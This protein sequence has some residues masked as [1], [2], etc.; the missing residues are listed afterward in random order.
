WVNSN[1]TA[2]GYDIVQDSVRTDGLAAY[3]NIYAFGSMLATYF[4]ST[5][6]IYVSYA[7]NLTAKFSMTGS[8][9]SFYGGLVAYRNASGGIMVAD[10]LGSTSPSNIIST[11]IGMSGTNTALYDKTIV[12]E[13]NN[14][15]YYTTRKVTIPASF[16]IENP[17]D[18]NYYTIET[19]YSTS[20]EY[21]WRVVGCDNAFS[22]NDSSCTTSTSRTFSVDNE[23]PTIS[24]IS[25]T[26]DSV[27]GGM[28]RVWAKVDDTPGDYQ[29]VA[30]ANYT[31]KY[32]DNSTIKFQGDMAQGGNVWNSGYLDFSDETLEDFTLLI[33]AKD[34]MGHWAHDHV[35]F[36]VNN[37]TPWFLFGTGSDEITVDGLKTFANIIQ[38]DFI[39]YNVLTSNLRIV[40]PSPS[41]TN[42]FAQS[43]INLTITNHNYSDDISTATWPDGEYTVY[44]NATTLGDLDRTDS[45][46]FWVDKNAPQWSDASPT[47][48]F[49][50][51]DLI[52]YINWTDIT[53]QGVNFTYNNTNISISTMLSENGTLSNGLYRSSALD[54]SSFRGST[55]YWKSEAI[56]RRNQTNSTG[57][58]TVTVKN[59][60]PTEPA[61]TNSTTGGS[62]PAIASTVGGVVSI[63][64]NASTDGDDDTL[65]YSLMY[66]NDLSTWKT[67]ATGLTTN[68]YSWDT[69]LNIT[70]VEDVFLLVNVTD[71]VE[72]NLSARY[73]NFTV[74]NEA[75]AITITDPVNIVVGTS[76]PAN[77]TTS[78][79]ATCTFGINGSASLSQSSTS[80]TSHI[81][82]ISS[83]AYNN[84][85]NLSVSCEDSVGNTN[86]TSKLF[87]ARET[88]LA[89]SNAWANKTV[90]IVNESVNITFQIP[91][92][93]DLVAFNWT[94][95]NGTTTWE[96]GMSHV[97]PDITS[98]NDLTYLNGLASIS[99]LAPGEYN[100]TITNL[101]SSLDADVADPD[102]EVGTIFE[103][104][105][106]FSQTINV[107]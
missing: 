52:L 11:Y 93:S 73:G 5:S 102:I 43:R 17:I 63:T 107:E 21:D 42:R 87:Q 46:T 24:S 95:T 38:S 36:T 92:R 19:N 2:Y 61:I 12:F 65:Y 103:V 79:S 62:T 89:F 80:G 77:I 34:H 101:T 27:V 32:K 88:G 72:G 25:P 104:F 39:A 96:R 6:N 64:W 105:T 56:D 49:A 94:I 3:S 48:I 33:S 98:T 99:T 45:R 29:D 28:F 37:A 41:T 90:L 10:I 69:T 1:A 74:D 66:S 75:P 50:S 31:V 16:I 91:T 35:N 78:E 84:T 54:V 23:A 57:W 83:L 82:T 53:L 85:Y 67:I 15:L 58:Q 14:N 4:D 51:E 106:Q 71:G 9:L 26:Q 86:E 60:A 20:T 97:S 55:F 68:S 13:N 22:N 70:A 18:S 100:L 7:E 81:I 47:E 59:N 40:G 8:N 44:F 30:S 76:T